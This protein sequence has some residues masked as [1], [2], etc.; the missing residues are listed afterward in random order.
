MRT[1]TKFKIST[2][3]PPLYDSESN[4]YLSDDC[5]KAAILNS[6][7]CSVTDLNDDNVLWPPFQSRTNCILDNINILHSEVEDIIKIL[8]IKKASSSDGI[9]YR[10]LRESSE[11]I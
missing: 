11:N 9:S 10:L 4:S 2:D 5:D 1:L 8:D 6:Y 3:I 7:F